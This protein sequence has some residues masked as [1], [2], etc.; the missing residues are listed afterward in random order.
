MPD[1]QVRIAREVEV[2]PGAQ[3]PEWCTL[4]NDYRADERFLVGSVDGEGP[5]PAYEQLIQSFERI[6]TRT[7]T[8]APPNAVDIPGLAPF[9]QAQVQ[10]TLR[11]PHDSPPGVYPFTV[12]TRMVNRQLTLRV[13]G[14]R[15]VPPQGDWLVEIRPLQPKHPADAKEPRAVRPWR[16]TARFELLI[17]NRSSGWLYCDIQLENVHPS[18]DYRRSSWKVSVPPWP[19]AYTRF[20]PQEGAAS[21]AQAPPLQAEAIYPPPRRRV[22]LSMRPK[23]AGWTGLPLEAVAETG[24]VVRV[25]CLDPETG[26][27]TASREFPVMVRYVP[28]KSPLEWLRVLQ[29]LWARLWGAGQWLINLGR[30]IFSKQGLITGGVLLT[31]LVVAFVVFVGPQKARIMFHNYFAPVQ[32]RAFGPPDAVVED[33][34]EGRM[35][36]TH[37][38]ELAVVSIPYEARNAEWVEITGGPTRYMDDRRKEKRSVAGTWTFNAG[39]EKRYTLQISAGREEWPGMPRPKSQKKRAILKADF[40]RSLAVVVDPTPAREKSLNAINWGLRLAKAGKDL[41][42]KDWFLKAFTIDSRNAAAAYQLGAYYYRNRLYTQAEE[43]L[44]RAERLDGSAPAPPKKLGDLYVIV[45]G[46]LWK[47]AGWYEKAVARAEANL[48]VYCPMAVEAAAALVDLLS[49]LAEAESNPRAREE[50]LAAAAQ[51]QGRLERLHQRCEQLRDK[52]E[53]PDDE[54]SEERDSDEPEGGSRR[55]PGSADR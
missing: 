17:T 24:I 5:T 15:I 10:L 44:T 2:L 46:D 11:A 1:P 39:E 21:A 40:G 35:L 7:A 30:R 55:E 16:K 31:V 12:V 6:Q 9:T 49:K 41:E 29:P 13:P 34:P 53:R 3:K 33:G 28:V 23:K 18:W 14:I 48:Q 27:A 19:Q 51:Q 32:V 42:A 45:G 38:G 8:E 20:A 22:Q 25:A 43:W 37:V 36:V 4:T 26:A 50:I 47:A 52:E 54:A